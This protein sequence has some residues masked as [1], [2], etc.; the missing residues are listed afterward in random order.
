M[1]ASGTVCG[2]SGVSMLAKSE[3]TTTSTRPIRPSCHSKQR[4]GGCQ[5]GKHRYATIVEGPSRPQ[6]RDMPNDPR[7]GAWLVRLHTSRDRIH[8]LPCCRLPN[9]LPPRIPSPSP[10]PSRLSRSHHKPVPAI[11]NPYVLITPPTPN[12]LRHSGRCLR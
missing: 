2:A 4:S 12:I 5:S 7:Q 1:N 8:Y 11:T 6:H 3:T 9:Q 10:N